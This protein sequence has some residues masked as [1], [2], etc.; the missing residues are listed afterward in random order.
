MYPEL[1]WRG[2][3]CSSKP[4]KVYRVARVIQYIQRA[5]APILEGHRSRGCR[6]SSVRLITAM[7]DSAAEEPMLETELALL[8][9]DVAAVSSKIDQETD[10]S[11]KKIL[12]QTQL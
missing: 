7:A 12:L 3:F 9:A 1:E 2:L 5:A 4:D 11:E 8:G 6:G 10:E